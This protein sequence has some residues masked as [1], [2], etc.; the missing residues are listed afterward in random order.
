MDMGVKKQYENSQLTGKDL[1]FTGSTSYCSPP[2]EDRWKAGQS[3]NPKGRPKGS[4]SFERRLRDLLMDEPTS[5]QIIALIW[6]RFVDGDEACT[7]LIC[8][9]AA[10]ILR[11]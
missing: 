6:Q 11:G 1:D 8:E 10:R 2:L 3:G 5:S 9:H 7:Q 4:V